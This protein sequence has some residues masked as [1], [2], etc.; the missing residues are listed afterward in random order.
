MSVMS[1]EDKSLYFNDDR[2]LAGAE[3]APSLSEHLDGGEP[4]VKLSSSNKELF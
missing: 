3:E 2:S 4:A 1:E